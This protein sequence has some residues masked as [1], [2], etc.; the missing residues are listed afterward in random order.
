MP[1]LNEI[2][3]Q[4]CSILISNPCLLFDIIPMRNIALPV[5]RSTAL[6]P[7]EPAGISLVVYSVTLLFKKTALL[8]NTSGAILNPCKLITGIFFLMG[9]IIVPL[10]ISPQPSLLSGL[11]YCAIPASRCRPNDFIFSFT[12]NVMV[13]NPT[14]SNAKLSA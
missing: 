5:G 10:I 7:I 8:L 2:F 9:D 1:I 13:L 11:K 3:S 14:F 12:S 4:V 6:L